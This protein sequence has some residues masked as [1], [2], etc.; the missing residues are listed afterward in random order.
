MKPKKIKYTLIG[1]LIAVG[2]WFLDS[3]IH[4]FLYGEYQ[5]E[6]VPR[7]LNELWMRTAILFLVTGFGIYIDISIS[8]MKK[9]LDERDQLHLKLQETLT[10]LLGGFVSICCECKKVRLP[11]KGGK[12]NETWD[13]IESYISHHSKI[14][15]SHGY[16]PECE[17]KFSR[18]IDERI[19]RHQSEALS[20]PLRLVKQNT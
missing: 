7:D 9:V 3:A 19:S 5:F 12:G 11:D 8:R 15:F 18:E 2:F 6:L 13:S 4:F 10:L 14:Q 1:L 16:C 20:V 17:R